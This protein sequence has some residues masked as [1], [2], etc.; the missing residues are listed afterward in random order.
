MRFLS[1]ITYEKKD[2]LKL[3]DALFKGMSVEDIYRK[4]KKCAEKKRT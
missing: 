3:Q 1:R 4:A 2:Y